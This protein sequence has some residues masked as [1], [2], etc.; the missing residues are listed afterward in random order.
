MTTNCAIRRDQQGI[1]G[2]FTR[3]WILVNRF[4]EVTENHLKLISIN[5]KKFDDQERIGPNLPVIPDRI[6]LALRD[7]QP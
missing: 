2:C 5:S 1:D 4:K 3:Q 7:V 6:W